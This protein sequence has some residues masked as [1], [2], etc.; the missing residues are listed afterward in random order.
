MIVSTRE[1]LKEIIES[2]K[3]TGKSVL[4]KKGVFDII[5]P[6]HIYAI[7]NFKKYADI[8]IILIQSDEF[9]RKKKGNKRPINDQE[10][11]VSVMDRI[12]DVDYVYADKSN[13]R[14]E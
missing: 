6:G 4:I 1:K 11:R 5:H 8:V 7:S 14:E 9:T 2:A 12:K 3:K 13:S 10:Q